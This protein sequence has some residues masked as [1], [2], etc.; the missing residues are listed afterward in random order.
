MQNVVPCRDQGLFGSVIKLII[1]VKGNGRKSLCLILPGRKWRELSHQT[2]ERGRLWR[3]I[4]EEINARR[5]VYVR[6]RG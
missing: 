5:P 2:D 4:R 6:H 1:S 3:V